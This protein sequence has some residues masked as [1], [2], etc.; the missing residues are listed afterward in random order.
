MEATKCHCNHISPVVLPD[1]H[2][3][4]LVRSG[5]LKELYKAGDTITFGLRHTCPDC[6]EKVYVP[7][8]IRKK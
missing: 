5:E 1:D 6:N 8:R 2:E 7:I 4:N 3:N